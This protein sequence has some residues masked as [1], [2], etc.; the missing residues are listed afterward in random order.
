MIHDGLNRTPDLVVSEHQ[1]VLLKTCLGF[2]PGNHIG[3]GDQDRAS[4]PSQSSASQQMGIE[5][6]SLD[7]RQAATPLA[8]GF[9]RSQGLVR[10]LPHPTVRRQLFVK[11]V[12][13][14]D[15]TILPLPVAGPFLL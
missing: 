9:N 11:G 6:V 3:T 13:E 15:R 10:P 7:Q 8:T 4:L 2:Q 14:A 12:C 1:D 5:L